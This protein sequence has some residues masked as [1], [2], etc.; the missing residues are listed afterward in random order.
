VHF[1]RAQMPIAFNQLTAWYSEL[2]T[3]FKKV[4]DEDILKRKEVYT[5]ADPRRIRTKYRS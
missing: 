2:T 1:T 4:E 3:A 5:Q